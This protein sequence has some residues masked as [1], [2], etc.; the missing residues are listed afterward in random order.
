VD[1]LCENYDNYYNDG[2]VDG[3]VKEEDETK[4]DED[5]FENQPYFSADDPLNLKSGYRIE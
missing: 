4:G 1:G 5:D 3:C 2:V